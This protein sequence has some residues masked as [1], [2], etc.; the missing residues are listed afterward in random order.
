[1]KDIY[2]RIAS[3]IICLLLVIVN[4]FSGN[5]AAV[6]SSVLAL[7]YCVIFHLLGISTE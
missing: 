4:A 2:L 6:V 7:Y 3:V 1:M 5:V